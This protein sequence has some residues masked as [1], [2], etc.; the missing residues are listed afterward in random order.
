M[1]LN[2]VG[3]SGGFCVRVCFEMKIKGNVHVTESIP[4]GGHHPRT[5]P[6]TMYSP[7]IIFYTYFENV[8]N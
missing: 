8:D 3:T 4:R 2:N 5:P 6:V 1:S 7:F